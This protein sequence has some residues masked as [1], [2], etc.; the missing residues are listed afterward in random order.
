MRRPRFTLAGVMCYEGQIAGLG[1]NAGRW[2]RRA[3]DPCDATDL[4]LGAARAPRGRR[5][6]GRRRVAP[7]EFVNGGGTGSLE[8]TAAEDCVTDI[9]AGSGLFGPALFDLYQSFRPEPAAY[10]VLEVVRRPGTAARRPCSAAGGWRPDRR[11]TTGCPTPV[12]PEGLR[13]VRTRERARCRPRWSARRV[14]GLRVGD[15]VW[16]RHAKAGELCEHV[17]F[18][19]L[20]D[21]GH[22]RGAGPDLSWRGALLLVAVTTSDDRPRGVTVARMSAD[23]RRSKLVDAAIRVMTRDGVAEA[24]TRAIAAEAGMPLGVFHYAFRSKQELMAMVTETIACA[25]RPTSTRPSSSGDTPD[26]YELVHAGLSA[27]FDHVVAHPEEH[28]VTYELT[29]TALREPELVEVAD[30]QY[31]LLPRREREALDGR[32][33]HDRLRL[34]RADPGRHPVRDLADGRSG[35]ELAGEG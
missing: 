4:G 9:A 22:G 20:V 12:W 30:R 25:A 27:Y 35:A 31:R 32:R 2:G 3:G 26:L 34:L 7:L 13:L 18:L 8:R 19:H 33:R 29:A 21:G 17:D 6:R 5:R 14:A 16:F 23:E 28:L 11:G 10:F 24:T 1:D 15:R